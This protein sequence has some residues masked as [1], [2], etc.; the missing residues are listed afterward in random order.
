MA[1]LYAVGENTDMRL[2]AES[3]AQAG[4]EVKLCADGMEARA[5]LSAESRSG[6]VILLKGSNGSGIW[7]IADALSEEGV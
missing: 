1:V 5:L 6:D 4:V 3:A 2:L 7:K